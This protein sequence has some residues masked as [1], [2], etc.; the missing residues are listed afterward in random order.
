MQRAKL[1][2]HREKPT[3]SA[4]ERAERIWGTGCGLVRHTARENGVRGELRALD[5]MVTQV[6]GRAA[7]RGMFALAREMKGAKIPEG[8][9]IERA[10]ALAGDIVRLAYRM[11]TDGPEAA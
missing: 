3:L 2:I 8:E 9:A 6:W 1:A 11:D 7:P 10:S 4:D 5:R